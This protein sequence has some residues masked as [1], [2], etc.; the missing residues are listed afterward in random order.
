MK[1]IL[2]SLLLFFSTVWAAAAENETLQFGAF[3][4]VSILRQSPHP[5]H[6]ALFVSG[7]GGWNLGVVEMAKAL[8]G[9][10][11][12]VVG[13]DITN[14]LKALENSHEECAYPAADFEL[15]SKSVQKNLDYPHYVTPLMVGYS[16]GATLVYATLVQAPSNTFLGAIS[17]GFCPDLMLKKPPCRG[18]GLQWEP[19]PGEKGYRFLPARH[20]QST[21]IA[22]QGAVDQVCDPKSTEAFVRKV[23]GAEI[24]IL[25]KVG[26]GFSVQR[27]WMPQFKETFLH[28]VKKHRPVQTSVP[29][30][31]RDLPLVEV[32]SH[33]QESQL[34]AVIISGDGGWAGI[35]RDIA[36]IL[37]SQGISVVGLNSLQY[38]WKGRT[39]DQSAKDL[40]RTIRYYLKAWSKKEFILLGYSRG[41]DVLP[42]MAN[43]LSKDLRNRVR[44]IAL[45]G[46]GEAVGFEFHV[47]EWIAA[48][49]G[50][51]AQPVLPEL[52]KLRGTK[53]LCFCGKKEPD[54]LC[55][56]IDEGL[57]RTFVLPGAHHFGGQYEAIAQTIIKEAEASP[58][59]VPPR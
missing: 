44:L 48:P 13:I 47:K 3:G 42:F 55:R 38:F 39:P 59:E 18:Y 7:D 30:E 52:E 17:L 22:F 54:S 45:L 34:L 23:E 6:V 57:G 40:E 10:D 43:R 5:S 58:S 1:S 37:S 32:Q 11:S 9:L 24:V 41:A 27:N 15:L 46:P 21:W 8:S 35:D 2:F 29:D 53:I 33:G 49:S 12:L 4:K 28:L 31:L 36:H 14:Y 20:L 56:K 16:S 26:H 51:Q 25:P 50:R 19:A